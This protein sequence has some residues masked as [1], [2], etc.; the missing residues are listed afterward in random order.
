MF[1]YAC[2]EG[3]YGLTGQLTGAR[4]VERATNSPRGDSGGVIGPLTHLFFRALR[5]IGPNT[6]RAMTIRT[7]TSPMGYGTGTR[8]VSSWNQF[9]IM[10]I[11]G[12]KLH[13]VRPGLPETPLTVARHQA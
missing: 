13:R 4:A 1:E 3:N 12:A 9:R 2:H 6:I 11:W 8:S 10:L 5:I 7:T